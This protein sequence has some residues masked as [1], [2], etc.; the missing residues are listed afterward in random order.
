MY[1]VKYCL[2]RIILAISDQFYFNLIY[3][4]TDNKKITLDLLSA[5]KKSQFIRDG[6]YLQN[7][8]KIL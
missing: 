6:A 4:F 8:L 2:C 7:D 3:N 1:V 5:L